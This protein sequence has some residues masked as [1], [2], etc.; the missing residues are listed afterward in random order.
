MISNLLS[1][2]FE[3]QHDFI[4]KL[5]SYQDLKL[6]LDVGAAA[7]LMTKKIKELGNQETKVIA[8]EPFPGNHQ[9]FLENTKDLANIELIKKAV[10]DTVGH[11]I[12][13][14]SSFVSGQEPGWENMPGY[15]S[16]G[17]LLQD[18][19]DINGKKPRENISDFLKENLRSLKRYIKKYVLNKQRIKNQQQSQ[20]SNVG[21]TINVEKIT[22]DSMIKDHVDFLKID[23]QGGELDVLKGAENLIKTQGIDVIYLEYSGD[24]RIIEFLTD[25]G[26]TIFDTDYMVASTKSSINFAE[27]DIDGVQFKNVRTIN[28]STGQQAYLANIRFSKSD[29]D[30]SLQAIKNQLGYI[31]TDLIC[32]NKL[33]LKKFIQ[34]VSQ[35]TKEDVNIF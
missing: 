20:I 31:Q 25:Y 3:N 11:Q 33:Y 8:F 21:T 18:S 24:L 27:V 34:N 1:Q 2:L 6:C 26:Y 22:L 30:T 29:F 19:Q 12:F 10:S 13:Y 35:L 14:V 15:S 7:G 32:V 5:I 4:Y 9:Y 23:V 17:Y 16:L 28:L